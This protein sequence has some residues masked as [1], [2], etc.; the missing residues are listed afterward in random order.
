VEDG[1][2]LAE[3]EFTIRA[4]VCDHGIPSVAY[5]FL[6]GR[7]I[8]VRKDRLAGRGLPPGPWL[9]ALKKAIAEETADARIQLPD[10]TSAPAGELAD[11]LLIVR[12]GKKLAYVADAADTPENRAK[13]IALAEA[14]HTLY[15]EAAFA[16]AGREQA[17]ATR[18]LTARAAAEISRAAGVERLAPFHFSK[19]YEHDPDRIYD[20]ILVAAGPVSVLRGR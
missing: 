14:A 5:A 20:E 19:R 2:L 8:N 11:D 4:A 18:H 3:P 16:E 6:S 7:E 1:V 13:L 17:V 9:G 15:C 12:P 10:G